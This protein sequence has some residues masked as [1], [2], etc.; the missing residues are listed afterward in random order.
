MTRYLLFVS[1]SVFTLC[2]WHCG[3]HRA[4]SGLINP[5][6]ADK[7]RPRDE[8][9]AASLLTCEAVKAIKTPEPLGSLDELPK[10]FLDAHNEIRRIYNLSKL[11]WD[12]SLAQ[13]AQRW[14][15]FLKDN[16][17]CQMQH[18]SHRKITENKQY[19]ENLAFNWISSTVPLGK[20]NYSP[21][22][23]VKAWS[24]ECEDY[25]YQDNSCIP[26]KKCGHFT[27]VVWQSTRRVGCAM[28]I[29]DDAENNYNEGRVE[30]WVCNYDPPGNYIG[31]K[32]Y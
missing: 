11:S 2:I 31:Q 14:A 9:P 16:N 13:Y 5:R 15:D 24:A 28:A 23:V 19:G 4:E 22:R 27:Q 20:Y 18:R 7:R 8:T 26:N 12:D 29:C 32:P 21:E 30:L 1:A 3:P 25:S 17:K 10:R 6:D